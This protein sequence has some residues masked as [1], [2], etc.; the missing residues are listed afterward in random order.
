[1]VTATPGEEDEETLR[2]QY[3]EKFNK[4]QEM[5]SSLLKSIDQ[6]HQENFQLAKELEK[7]YREIEI[8]KGNKSA[9]QPVQEAD[10][11]E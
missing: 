6:K 4:S 1:M 7:I 8:A 11:A 10:K 5:V 3:T 9:I 2:D